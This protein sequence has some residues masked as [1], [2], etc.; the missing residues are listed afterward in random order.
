[1]A[2]AIVDEVTSDG[3]TARLIADPSGTDYV[4]V[5]PIF[6]PLAVE[7]AGAREDR[8]LADEPGEGGQ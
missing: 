3:A 4:A 7:A 5:D 8:E 6:A 1:M 2:V